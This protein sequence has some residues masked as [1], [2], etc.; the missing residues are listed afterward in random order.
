M[1]KGLQVVVAQVVKFA[2]RDVFEVSNNE[3]FLAQLNGMN[4][5][6]IADPSV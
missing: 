4:F 1:V 3:M 6:L 2:Q 5:L